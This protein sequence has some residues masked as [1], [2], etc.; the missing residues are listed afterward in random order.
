MQSI[1]NGMELEDGFIAADVVSFVEGEEK[2]TVGI[3]IHSGRH[4]IVR[5]I[6]EKLGYKVK[7]LDRVSFAGLTKKSA[8]GRWRLLSPREVSY[9]KMKW[10]RKK[11]LFPVMFFP[12]M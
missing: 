10:Y 1:A 2:D 4:R 7:A 11:A 3:E 9:L 8:C 5:R 6:F 12:R